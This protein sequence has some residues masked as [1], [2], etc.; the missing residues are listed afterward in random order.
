VD[1]RVNEN[2]M[3]YA[4]VAKGFQ[5]GGFQAR[6][7]SVNDI[8]TPYDP[9]TVLTYEGGIKMDLLDQMLRLNVAYYWNDYDDLQLNSLN[10]AAGGG[11]IT[12]NAAEAEVH[13]IE[14]ELVAAPT[15]SLNIFG[16]IAT[17]ENEYK[18][19]AANVSGVTLD[20]DIAGTPVFSSTLGLDYTFNFSAGSLVVGTDWQHQHSHHP[21]STNADVTKV[22]TLD[23]INAYIRYDTPDGDWDVGLYAKNLTDEEYHFTGFRFSSFQSVYA[24]DPLTMM[25]NINYHYR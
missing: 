3:T 10:V 23:L 20:S 18:E 4:Y 24:A 7:F 19:L 15:E 14:V 9:T 2:I 5:A 1:Y 13:G 12:Q 25:V 6:P 21:G 17:A 22:P 11:T 16:T 8:D